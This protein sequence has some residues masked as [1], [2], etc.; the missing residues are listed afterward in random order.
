MV[1]VL[2]CSGFLFASPVLTHEEATKRI[3]NYLLVRDSL[4]AVKAGK[5]ALSAFPHSKNVRTA[6][7]E[8]LC[9]NGNETEAL[10]LWEESF[11]LFQDGQINRNMLETLAWGVLN[12]AESS[13]QLNIQLHALLGAAFTRDAKAVPLL[14]Q[15]LHSS[16]A[17]IRTVAIKLS[18]LFGDAA[19][20][21][22][23]TDRE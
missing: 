10:A 2:F 13:S 7:F 23:I 4:R 11:D 3:Y 18:A 5:E 14:M 1:L 12:K 15:Q 6:L 20:K 9:K 16:N 21:T 22:W 19:L 17:L 8:A